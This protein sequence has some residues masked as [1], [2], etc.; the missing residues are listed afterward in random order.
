MVP[1]DRVHKLSAL[2]APVFACHHSPTQLVNCSIDTRPGYTKPVC[3][4]TVST[5]PKCVP[6]IHASTHHG[7]GYQPPDTAARTMPRIGP[8]ARGSLPDPVTAVSSYRPRFSRSPV[9]D[10]SPNPHSVKASSRSPNSMPNTA[11]DTGSRSQGDTQ[12]A[13]SVVESI[14]A[15]ADEYSTTVSSLVEPLKP[16]RASPSN[17][18]SSSSNADVISNS[19]L[20]ESG[21]ENLICTG[22]REVQTETV[23]SREVLT[24]C[25]T[26]SIMTQGSSTRSVAE[27]PDVSCTV[28]GTLTKSLAEVVNDSDIS[29]NAAESS[30]DENSGGLDV[31][32]SDA[33][34]VTCLSR[35]GESPG[36][37]M[38]T[39][40]VVDQLAS[41]LQSGLNREPVPETVNRSSCDNSQL[42]SPASCSEV[43]ETVE[44]EAADISL[45]SGAAGVVKSD[46]SSD[47]E[48]T[49]SS[50][51][52][53]TLV[54]MFGPPT[55][56]DAHY[57]MS[58]LCHC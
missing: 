46:S 53:S 20:A 35:T 56:C 8:H 4:S 51:L 12:P 57:S 44:D 22:E 23:G 38:D 18:S 13:V 54:D 27:Q 30:V 3:T 21:S 58:V 19:P 28:L 47:V 31:V 48:V 40:P 6:V 29:G 49:L 42:T 55:D 1:A 24:P 25:C 41:D 17:F 32:S 9:N 26:V 45:D 16:Q 34:G 50:R 39:G 10:P 37:V 43:P 11:V 52:I 33:K 15:A 2:S 7:S 5:P 36:R 14:P